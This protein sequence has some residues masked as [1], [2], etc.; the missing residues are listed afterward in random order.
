MSSITT[1]EGNHDDLHVDASSSQSQTSAISISQP[2]TSAEHQPSLTEIQMEI[3]DTVPLEDMLVSK[4]DDSVQARPRVRSKAVQCKLYSGV[5]V[6]LSPIKVSQLKVETKPSTSSIRS[7]SESTSSVQSSENY[8]ES[9]SGSISTDFTLT[10]R[11][12]IKLNLEN[13]TTFKNLSMNCTIAKLQNRPRLYMGLPEN[14]YYTFQLL[15]KYC[16][17]NSTYI[18]LS[19]SKKKS[20]PDSHL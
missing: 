16:K 17:V 2:S 6:A 12:T 9:G 8:S 1:Q 7:I 20:K 15:Q 14:A 10:P 11:E 4:R 3:R 19:N 13:K 5:T 18:F